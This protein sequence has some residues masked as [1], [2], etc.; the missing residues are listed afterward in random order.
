MV[1]ISKS[2]VQ[3]SEK[4]SPVAMDGSNFKE[5]SSKIR[6]GIAGGDSLSGCLLTY[7]LI[8]SGLTTVY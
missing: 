6:V 7:G 4:E 5:Q 8:S 1:Q 2:K 3:R